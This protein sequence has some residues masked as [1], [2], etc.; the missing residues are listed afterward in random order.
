M[1]D[2]TGKCFVSYR[3]SR[4]PEAAL[5]V[6]SLRDVGVPTWQ[7]IT[8]LDAEPTEDGL[9]RVLDDPSTASALLWITPE[10]ADSPII[11][12][13]EVPMIV[14]RRRR[15]DGFFVQPVAA[16][17]LDYGDAAQIAGKH[18]GVADLGTWNLEK[19]DANPIAPADAAHVA[20]LVLR[21]RVKEIAGRLQP[22]EPLR[23]SIYTR[24]PAPVTAPA[25]VVLDWSRRFD[26]RLAATDTWDD[27]LLPALAVMKATIGEVA[28]GRCVE[29]SGLVAL[30]AAIALGAAFL[31]PAGLDLAWCQPRAGRA[32]QV[33][34][35]SAERALASVYI[36]EISG[37]ANSQEMAVVVSMNHDAEEALRRS[38]SEVPTFRG[39]V[40]LRGPGGGPADLA[41][42][43]E[44]ADAAFRLVES[45]G[46]ARR[47]WRDI[48]RI[49]LFIA[50][51]AGLAVLVG[52]LLNGFGPVQTYE[53]V[54][55][56][57]V[58]HYR[59]A[60]LLHPGA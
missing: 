21:R 31:A 38:E 11:K 3:R 1:T 57:S 58:G 26:G 34:S 5:L 35:L 15:R 33:W 43:G 7:D 32:D 25:A 19:V 48:R 52:R 22:G 18:L 51:P 56:D 40:R 45:I 24:A 54:P 55:N 47:R 8:N 16:G 36:D 14:E 29:A 50:G 9:R 39:Y 59:R 49:H 60:A 42:P 53:H 2:P 37:D 41:T 44:A 10:V 6:L 27:R 17:G 46:G 28:P 12:K 4:A 30:P 20:E 13:L 23:L